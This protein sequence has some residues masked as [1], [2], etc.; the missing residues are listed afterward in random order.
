MSTEPAHSSSYRITTDTDDDSDT[1]VEVRQQLHD[2]A[3]LT[4]CTRFSLD[5][6]MTRKS[7]KRYSSVWSRS[8]SPEAMR[9]KLLLES[10]VTP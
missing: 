3:S 9:L 1:D 6:Y 2:S 8:F 5:T 4:S 10:A 7:Q